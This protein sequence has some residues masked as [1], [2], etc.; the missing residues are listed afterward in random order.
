M[1]PSTDDPTKNPAAPPIETETEILSNYNSNNSRLTEEVCQSEDNFALESDQRILPHDHQATNAAKK[2]FCAFEMLVSFDNYVWVHAV[3]Q[4]VAVDRLFDSIAHLTKLVEK[5]LLV[6][7]ASLQLLIR[8][9]GLGLRYMVWV[10]ERNASAV[11]HR[12]VESAFGETQVFGVEIVVRQIWLAIE[13]AFPLRDKS[14]GP[15]LFG[16]DDFVRKG[17]EF[18]SL[19]SIADWSGNV[20]GFVRAVHINGECRRK[21]NKAVRHVAIEKV[22]KLDNVHDLENWVWLIAKF[23]WIY[24]QYRFFIDIIEWRLFVL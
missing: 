12:Q 15:E 5:F 17:L 23:N 9:N 3:L 13:A 21:T 6:R 8:T 19:G 11:F 20:H 14:F 1:S 16:R 18:V 10:E 22:A 4:A 7:K 24:A 2:L